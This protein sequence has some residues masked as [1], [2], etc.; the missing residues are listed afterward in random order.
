MEILGGDDEADLRKRNGDENL[1]TPMSHENLLT[2]CAMLGLGVQRR[3]AG[4]SST[5]ATS[6]TSTIIILC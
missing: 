6:T 4:S 2:P 1:L 5:T 3:A